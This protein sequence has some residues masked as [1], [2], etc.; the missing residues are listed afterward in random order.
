MRWW[1]QRPTR[2]QVAPAWLPADGAILF[3]TGQMIGRLLSDWCVITRSPKVAR[4]LARPMIFIASPALGSN[5]A[6]Q[7]SNP[8][9]M[10]Y[11][12]NALPTES[13]GTS[14][15]LGHIDSSV[16]LNF[17]AEIHQR[18][19]LVTMTQETSTFMTMCV[20]IRC[21]QVTRQPA[22]PITNHQQRQ[23]T[24]HTLALIEL[25]KSPHR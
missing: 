2:K 11:K 23:N 17:D 16:S 15:K 21:S 14:Y 13:F 20:R 9:P 5:L 3:R 19:T 8:G 6:H 1:W 7:G 10:G 25:S 12:S 22:C 4:Q 18:C 24:S